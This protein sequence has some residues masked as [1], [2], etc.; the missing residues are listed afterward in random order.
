MWRPVLRG[1]ATLREIN[2]YYD[3]IDLLD[4]NEAL[5]LQDTADHR[6]MTPR[7]P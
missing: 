2:E 5:D 4:I 3:I 7:R 1:C 6:A